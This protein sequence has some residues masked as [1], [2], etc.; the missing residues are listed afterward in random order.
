MSGQL[1]LIRPRNLECARNG[2]RARDAKSSRVAARC[3]AAEIRRN[4]ASLVRFVLLFQL[5]LNEIMVRAVQI[6]ACSRPTRGEFV[7]S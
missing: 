3:V 6:V 4:L 1:A 2:L 5:R 7:S